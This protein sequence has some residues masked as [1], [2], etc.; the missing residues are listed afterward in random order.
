MITGHGDDTYRYEGITMN[1]SSNI[2]YAADT[3]PLKTYLRTRMDVISSYPEPEAYRLEKVIAERRGVDADNVVVTAGAVDAIYLIAQAL[4]PKCSTYTVR[5][6]TFSEYDDACSMF[7]YTE[8]P[9]GIYW[10]CCPNNPTGAF[11]ILEESAGSSRYIIID[12]SYEAYVKTSDEAPYVAANS[13]LFAPHSSLMEVHSMTKTFSIPGLRLGYIIARDDICA[14]L[15]RNMRPWTVNALAIEAGLWLM[16]NDLAGIT[17]INAWLENALRLRD[18]LNAVEGI[19]AYPSQTPFMMCRVK[20]MTAAELKELLA[21][22]HGMLIRDL[23]NIR[24]LTPYHFRICAR[25]GEENHALVEAIRK[26]LK[27]V[28][29]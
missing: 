19:T 7:G 4:R 20:G 22:H 9:D 10:F 14:L 29:W 5:R 15:R 25:S 24:G 3:E 18:A 23:S 26:C 13:P 27:R 28:T 17:D 1:F 12:R 8:G 2:C 11:P 16:E 21:K 6:P